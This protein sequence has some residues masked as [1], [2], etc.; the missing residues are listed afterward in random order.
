M[1]VEIK[2]ERLHGIALKGAWALSGDHTQFG[3]FSGLEVSEERLFAVTDFGWW[4]GAEMGLDD[5]LILRNARVAPMRGPMGLP[6]S[7]AGGDAE[8]LV[9]SGDVLSVAF[10]RDHRVMR[11]GTDG[12]LGAVIRVR[13]FERLR[14]NLGLEGLA[15]HPGGGLLA[16]TEASGDYLPVFRLGPGDVRDQISFHVPGRHQI[17]GA[18]LGPDG[19]LYVVRRKYSLIKGGSMQIVRYSI[20]DDGWPLA[21]SAERLAFIGWYSGIDNMEGISVERGADGVLRLWL[22][23]DDNFSPLQ[24]TLLVLF[25][26]GAAARPVAATG[27]GG[28]G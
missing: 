21:E 25:E 9:L 23:S 1:P 2:A 28:S 12:R 7:K 27:Q 11:L 4:F 10:E 14:S 20:G 17:T 19:Q 8:D 22:I 5:G 3:G 26:I 15:A 6:Y 16:L 24:R 18:D 13:A